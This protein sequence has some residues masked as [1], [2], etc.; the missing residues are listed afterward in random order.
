MKHEALVAWTSLYIAVGIMAAICALLALA[1]TADDWR[2]GRCRPSL[3]SRLD[4]TLL[5]AK[6]WLRWQINYL[7]GMPVILA[8]ALYYAWSVGF[9]VFWNL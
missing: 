7:T 8:I 3:V 4:K 2:T 6:L 1:V 5:V 9:S